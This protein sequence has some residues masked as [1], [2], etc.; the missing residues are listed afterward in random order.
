VGPI[1][2]SLS[3]LVV[4]Q[5]Q[6]H[7][8]DF[9]IEAFSENPGM[10]ASNVIIRNNIVYGKDAVGITVGGYWPTAACTGD[11]GGDGS[12]NVYVVNNTLYANDMSNNEPN[13]SADGELQT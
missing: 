3:V 11:C 12:Q 1:V 4:E 8:N 13:S 7:E 6:V 2:D 9:G 5:N 10:F